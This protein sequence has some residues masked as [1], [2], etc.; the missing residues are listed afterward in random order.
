MDS[1]NTPLLSQQ[2]KA[3]EARFQAPL[4]NLFSPISLRRIRA[5]IS[6]GQSLHVFDTLSLIYITSCYHGFVDTSFQKEACP[7]EKGKRMFTLSFFIPKRCF[8]WKNSLFRM[9]Q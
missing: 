7:G 9:R 2:S 4:S 8:T 5:L 1:K 6:L 3:K